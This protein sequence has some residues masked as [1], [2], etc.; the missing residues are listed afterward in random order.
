[1][2]FRGRLGLC[3]DVLFAVAVLHG[4]RKQCILGEYVC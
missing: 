2:G 4:H 1:L 3:A